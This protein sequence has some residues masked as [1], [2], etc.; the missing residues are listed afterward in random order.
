[1]RKYIAKSTQRRYQKWKWEVEAL[2]KS[3]L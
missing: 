2:F 1:M 3:W